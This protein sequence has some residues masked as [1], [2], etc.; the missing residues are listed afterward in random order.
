MKD[1]EF[2]QWNDEMLSLFREHVG[3]YPVYVITENQN[4]LLKNLRSS[5]FVTYE[6]NLNVKDVYDISKRKQREYEKAFPMFTIANKSIYILLDYPREYSTLI[7]IDLINEVNVFIN[8]LQKIA[9]LQ[10]ILDICDDYEIKEHNNNVFGFCG[11]FSF[12]LYFNNIT[13]Y[14]SGLIECSFDSLM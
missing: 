9:C 12:E 7:K 13:I 8:I 10:Y 2:A 3:D 4:E 6:S 1:L 11:H 14:A 5:S